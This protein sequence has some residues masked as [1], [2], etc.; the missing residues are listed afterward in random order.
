M[1]NLKPKSFDFKSVKGIS[2]KQLEEHYKLYVGYVSKLND[3]WNTQ[4]MPANYTDSNAIYSKMRS[5]KLG[6]TYSLDGVKLH[7]L[8]FENM[9][10]GSTTPYGPILDAINNQFSSYDNFISYL[11]NVGLSMRGWTTLSIDSIDNKLHIIGSDLHDTGA[12][13]L[14]YPVLTMDVYEHAY[15][16]DFGTDKKKYIS[17]FIENINWKVL[18]DRFGKY[19]SS[20]QF[21]DMNKYRYCPYNFF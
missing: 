14:S 21:V 5:L 1:Y 4:Y 2:M 20:M 18:N 15:F 13:W 10:G 19:V 17:T 7:S 6:E 8:Y 12:V 11:T 3:I 16:M 9:T